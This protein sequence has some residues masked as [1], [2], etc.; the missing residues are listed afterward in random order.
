[1]HAILAYLTPAYYLLPSPGFSSG[2]WGAGQ[3]PRYEIIAWK[4]IG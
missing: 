4:R 3:G 2:A 1:L